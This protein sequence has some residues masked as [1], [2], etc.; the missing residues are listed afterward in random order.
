MDKPECF[1]HYLDKPASVTRL[2]EL[3]CLSCEHWNYLETGCIN[4]SIEKHEKEINKINKKRSDV[5]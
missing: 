3:G 5:K 4:K 2:K 1:S